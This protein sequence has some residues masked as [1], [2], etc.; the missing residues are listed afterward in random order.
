MISVFINSLTSGG[1]EKVVLTLLD[2]FKHFESQLELLLI[3]KDRF[4]ELP[5]SVPSTYLTDYESLEKG[6]LKIPY[7]FV[8]A[9]R[10]KKSITQPGQIVQSHLLRASF[11]NVI[12]KL[13]GSKHHAQ[14]VVHSRINFDHKPFY[15]RGI[16]KWIYTQIFNRADS[17]VSIC[18][19]MKNDLDGYLNLKNHPKHFAIHNPH[20][21]EE[22][23]AKSKKETTAFNFS[24][25]KRYIISVG[26]LVN[27]K[28]I[29]DLITAFSQIEKK[30][31]NTELIILGDGELRA[32]FEKYCHDLALDQKVHFLGFQQNPFA[33]IAKSDLMV[34][35]SEW[36]GLPNILIESMACGTAVISS[37]CISGPRE[38]INPN[39]DLSFQLKTDL[40]IGEYGI[41]Y[42]VGNIGLLSEALLKCLQD[43]A[44]IHQ[45]VQAGLRRCKDFDK[46]KIAQQYLQTFNME[47]QVKQSAK[48]PAYLK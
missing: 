9:Y 1:A 25:D 18:E 8:C 3:E 29:D 38:I 20:N 22:I 44:M 31:P 23:E 26:R 11:I 34:L 7:L 14:I 4:Y 17:V 24:S 28:R 36:E 16:A 2:Q 47:N 43:D 42:P 27:G 13:L 33:Y 40:E 21:L 6:P 32:E 39:S 37:D 45:F 15:S 35:S 30:V 48:L 10:L 46:T 12:A 41:L 5:A 19:V